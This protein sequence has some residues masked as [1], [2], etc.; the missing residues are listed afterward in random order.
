METTELY[1]R[2][3]EC[4][5]DEIKVYRHLLDI[6][7]KEK[8]ILISAKTD[9]LV[10][11]NK[12]KDAMLAKL[13][14]IDRVREKCARELAQKVGVS[15]DE[16]RLLEIATK[17]ETR[18]GDRLRSIHQTLTLMVQRVK[19]L[20][21]KNEALVKSALNNVQGAMEALRTALGDS[22]TYRKQGELKKTEV[23]SGQLV[24]RE[25]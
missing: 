19:D 4:L 17:F 14:Q 13:R 15:I 8:D 6:I 3:V 24:S 22:P 9:D 20:N 10:E 12:A 21:Q 1:N 11:N 25:V 23:L 18:D 16:P 5:D 7:R 2:F